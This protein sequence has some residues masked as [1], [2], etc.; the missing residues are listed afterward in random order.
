MNQLSQVLSRYHLVIV[1]CDRFFEPLG[2]YFSSPFGKA[3]RMI[4]LDAGEKLKSIDSFSRLL[5][6]VSDCVSFSD[7]QVHSPKTTA[8]VCVGGGSVSDMGTLLA[9]I[10]YR[11]VD[12]Y[13]VPTTLLAMVDAAVGGKSAING[14]HQ[15]QTGP[16]AK[17]LYGTIHHP[18][19]YVYRSEFLR[20]LSLQEFSS[21]LGEW[22]KHCLL[23]SN[24]RFDLAYRLVMENSISD[25]LEM[26]SGK[27]FSTVLESASFKHELVK[28]SERGSLRD[29]LNLGHT[30][31]H[32]LESIFS[33]AHG[34]AIAHGVAIEALLIANFQHQQEIDAFIQ[35]Q[36]PWLQKWIQ[37]NIRLYTDA[38]W[39][40]SL[41]DA[42]QIHE[43][44][45]YLLLAND[46]KNIG[47]SV[48]FALRG[49]EGLG[50]LQPGYKSR[51]SGERFCVME[52]DTVAGL[53]KKVFPYYGA[54]L[55][56]GLS[57]S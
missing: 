53:L 34:K 32:A 37:L 9:S 26:F 14:T 24:D 2:Q 54:L 45:W 40:D 38:K 43:E 56:Q 11:G 25:L 17:N 20:T 42:A 33:M 30:I 23:A 35:D 52:L 57:S 31:G 48:S 29:M 27:Y 28:A 46:K 50:L 36:F 41:V 16:R 7:Q 44:S 1:L 39:I 22:L 19:A 21:G 3:S 15:N 47:S 18:K 6:H 4:Y 5:A 51:S 12:H 49:R 10:L 13:V 55:K 8:V